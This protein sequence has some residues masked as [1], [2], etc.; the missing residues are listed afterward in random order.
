VR[1]TIDNDPVSRDWYYALLAA[2]VDG[3]VVFRLNDGRR[4]MAEQATLVR[5][6]GIW[7]EINRDGA[8]SPSPTAPHIR[9][10]RQDHALDVN[11]VDGGRARLQAWLRQHGVATA[12]TV[13][14]EPW[15]IEASSAG[16]LHAF[17]MRMRPLLDDPALVLAQ[18][19]LH[20]GERGPLVRTVQIYLVRGR[21]LGR[22]FRIARRIGTYGPAAVRAVKRFQAD[23]R[24][25]PD[26]VVGE[27]TFAALRERY[28]RPR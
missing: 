23:A 3:R 28:G 2:R 12:Q 24:L 16:A 19:P 1:Y 20:P 17:A 18:N 4:T 7:S 15:H 8:A 10:G 9:V 13:S 26:G 11:D 25:D 14:G 21:W 5:L 22:S 27:R 6:R